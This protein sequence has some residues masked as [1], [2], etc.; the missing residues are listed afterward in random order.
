[1]S[2]FWE[3][4]FGIDRSTHME[5]ASWSLDW[6]NLPTSDGMLALLAVVVLGVIAVVMLYRWDAKKQRPAIRYGLTAVRL[7]LL[8]LALGMLLEPVLKLTKEEFIPSRVVVLVDNSPSMDLRDAWKDEANAIRVAGAL[9]MADADQLRQQTR[10]QLAARALSPE[11]QEAL[12]KG[13]DRTVE[14][15][16]FSDR[17]TG[18]SVSPR[19]LV[20]LKTD[21]ES[22]AIGTA[23]R[24]AMVTYSGQPLAGVLII[25]DGRSTSGEPIDEVLPQFRDESIPIAGI[26]VGTV[27]GP[28]NASITEIEVNPVALTGDDNTLSVHVR[29]RGMQDTPADLTVEVRR[30]GGVWEELG[31]QQIILGLDETLQAYPFHFSENRP[32]RLEFRAKIEKAGPELSEDDNIAIAESRIV[33]DRM[34]VLLVAGTSFPEVQFLRNAL[35][36]DEKIEMSSWLQT[37]DEDYDHLGDLPI[38][39]L[40]VTQEELD[41][42]DCVVLYDPDPEEWPSNFP[43][44]LTN[45]VSRAGGGLVYMAGEQN[46][47]RCFDLQNDPE[48]EWLKMLPVI[49]EPGLFR[50]QEMIRLSTRSPWQLSVTDLGARDPIFLFN[51]DGEANS[52]VLETLPGMYWHFT[53]TRAK[54]SAGVLA[55]HGD[56]RMVNEFGPEVLLAT[57]RVGPGRVFFLGFDSTYRWR[58][59]SEQH[60]DGFWARVIDRAGRNK[61]LGGVY[62][63]RLTTAQQSYRPGSTATVVARFLDEESIDPSLDV[64]HGQVEHGDSDPMPVTLTPTGS[65]G[66]FATNIPIERPGSYFLRVWMGDEGLADVAKAATLAIESRIPNEEYDNPSLDRGTLESLAVATGGR[67]A[68][69][70][71]TSGI[72]DAF[73]IGKVSRTLEDRHPIWHAPAWWVTIFLL[74]CVEWILRKRWR[75]I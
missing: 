48:L 58:Y 73:T 74:L 64:L 61:Q 11:L 20:D 29:S 12:T 15:H 49:R 62:P 44:L 33:R 40:P 34:R 22:T 25:G 4:L 45:F 63:F 28:R 18:E 38:R 42:Y 69:V 37:A 71:D 17:F 41:D 56:P 39:R 46:T 55:V 9:K 6:L 16:P 54:P 14:I 43:S 65:P 19:Q 72:S 13:G 60:F 8:L 57:H 32:T 53:V 51:D 31:H 21:G 50:S 75:L 3:F 1:M 5:G 2:Q 70:S 35:Y 36:R 52:R 10:L 26:A 30:N 24:Q 47:A 27:E 23:L 68:D 7:L 59:L 67:V 66:E